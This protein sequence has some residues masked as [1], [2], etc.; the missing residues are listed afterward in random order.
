MYHYLCGEFLN[1]LVVQSTTQKRRVCLDNNIILVTIVDDR[2]LL[3]EWVQLIT[4]SASSCTSGVGDIH[5]YLVNRRHLE[6]GLSDLLHVLCRACGK[7]AEERD[8]ISDTT[9]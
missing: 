4:G 6:T 5:L 9:Y 8:Q 7:S 3:A 2:F 1:D